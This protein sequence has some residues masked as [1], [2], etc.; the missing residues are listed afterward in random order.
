MRLKDIRFE[1]VWSASGAQGFFGEGYRFH[2]LFKPFGLNF[3]GS[4][5]VGKTTT[6]FYNKGNMALKPDLMPRDLFPDCIKVYPFK[7]LALNAVGLSGPG[8][9]ALFETGEYQKNTK[10]FWLSFMAIGKTK[11][12]RL[13]ELRRYVALLKKYLP[14]FRTR[15]GLQ[16]NFSCPN[17]NHNLAELLEEI[18]ECLTIASELGIPLMPK[19]NA[20]VSVEAARDISY[21]PAC[22]GL[23]I[24]NTIPYGQLSDQIPWKE[25]FGS[26]LPSESP[27]A[28]YGG[29]GL[30]G[31]LLLPILLSW[32]RRARQIGITKPINA[33][34]GILSL[35]DA[36]SVFDTLGRG[37]NSIFLG[38][39]GFLRPWRVAGI[40]RG[41]NSL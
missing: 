21:H 18:W 16:L 17:T 25:L 32:I 41:I 4:T 13:Q 39:I 26:D 38:S 5:P 6:L 27:L 14:G 40:I 30:S 22:D 9:E 19:L 11:E 10:P 34:G 2:P 12:V 8:A 3:Y 37:N 29:G 20:L 23:C 28:K 7:G 36:I 35:P 33:G 15:V 1:R 31:A 24:S